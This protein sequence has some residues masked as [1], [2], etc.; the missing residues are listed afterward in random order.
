MRYHQLE[1]TADYD[2]DPVVPRGQRIKRPGGCE[3][4]ES[5][6]PEVGPPPEVVVRWT[7]SDAVLAS[8]WGFGV[9]RFDLL[10]ALEPQ[11][12]ELLLL[13]RLADPKG[14]DIPNYRTFAGRHQILLRGGP[15]SQHYICDTCGRIAYTYVP[16]ESPYVTASSVA[17]RAA[18]YEAGMELLVNE[19]IRD[20]IGNRWSHVLRISEVPVMQP[21]D[22]LPEDLTPWPTAEQ[23]VGYRRT[24]PD[25]RRP[26]GSFLAIDKLARH[27]NTRQSP[28]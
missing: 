17:S 26:P 3:E 16:R 7:K 6:P 23:R 19:T 21:L 9:I 22:R 25:F 12:S 13:G 2:F 27:D 4:C 15:E 8:A 10:A 24:A 18:I 20:R 14:N 5:L 11:A 1:G 28:P